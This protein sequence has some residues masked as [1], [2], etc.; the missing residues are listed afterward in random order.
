MSSADGRLGRYVIHL[1]VTAADLPGACRLAR[2]L[3]RSLS[4][5]PE[6]DTAGAEVSEE[7]NQAVRHPVFCDRLLEN[8]VAARCGLAAEHAGACR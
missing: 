3:G 6:I 8:A 5:L 4:W 2:G 7:D 1:P